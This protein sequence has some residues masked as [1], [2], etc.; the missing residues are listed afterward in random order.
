MIFD[1]RETPR[2]AKWLRVWINGRELTPYCFRC[3]VPK[4]QGLPGFG[5]ASVYK[6]DDRGDFVIDNP[7]GPRDL[8]NVA[9][10]TRRGIVWWRWHDSVPQKVKDEYAATVDTLRNSC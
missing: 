4:R 5:S 10:E 1:I 7:D 2:F 9:K 6:T 8:S 3:E